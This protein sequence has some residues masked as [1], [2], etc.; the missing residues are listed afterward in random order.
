MSQ[1]IGTLAPGCGA[2]HPGTGARSV[3]LGRRLSRLPLVGASSAVM[4]TTCAT[5]LLGFLF[6]SVTTNGISASAVGVATAAV[7]LAGTSALLTSNGLVPALMVRLPGCTATEARRLLRAS[8]LAGGASSAV[9][10]AVATVALSQWAGSLG[11]LRS[12][13]ITVLAALAGASAAATAIC[14][15]ACVA[16]RRSR[17]MLVRAT[18]HSVGK[19]AIL[20][21]GVLL[22][23]GPSATTAAGVILA[24]WALPGLASSVAAFRWLNRGAPG[25]A[26]RSHPPTLIGRLCRHATDV[27]D[28]VRSLPGL[29]HHHLAAIAGPLP[30]LALP[31]LIAVRLSS[32]DAAHFSVTWAVGSLC[33]M[34]SPAVS[35]ALL[36]E[37]RHQPETMARRARAAAGITG[38]L[39][40]VPVAVLVVAGDRVLGVF[41]P[42]YV[43]GYVLLV[44]IVASALPDGVTN[45]A[46]AVLRARGR[47][48]SVTVL[49]VAMAVI[50]LAVAWFGAPRFG[51]LA[52][53]LGWVAAQ[54]GGAVGVAVAALLART[55]N[56]RRVGAVGCADVDG[57]PKT[58]AG[59]DLLGEGG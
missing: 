11:A 19:L 33:M 22:V 25:E 34:V 14:D 48:A 21:A 51:L 42:S 40:A 17:G 57:R 20:A 52:A 58:V 4:S 16:R 1:A 29:R 44:A 37:A 24:A 8:L 18:A 54:T 59:L 55:R 12:P 45:I 9:T 2:D 30:S 10:A 3:T 31:F 13:G 26:T 35:S 47:F 50:A 56:W 5:S 7:S 43:A 6:W 38:A 49:N 15:A 53:G 23:P 28:A 39:L 46:I 27:V 36:I 32:T 41:G